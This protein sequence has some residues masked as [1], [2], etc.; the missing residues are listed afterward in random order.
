LFEKTVTEPPR[1]Y[2]RIVSD[3]ADITRD[4][5]FPVSTP[6]Y[7]V[8]FSMAGDFNGSPGKEL[9]FPQIDYLTNSY[10]VLGIKFPRRSNA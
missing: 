3:R 1:H 10:P 9:V 4:Y 6:D 2:F 8:S 7:S 5:D